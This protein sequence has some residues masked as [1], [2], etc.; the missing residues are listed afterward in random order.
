MTYTCS[1][2]AR[3]HAHASVQVRVKYFVTLDASTDEITRARAKDPWV[4]VRETPEQYIAETAPKLPAR[5]LEA[6]WTREI[7]DGS[8]P[9]ED[10]LVRERDWVLVRD[11][12]KCHDPHKPEDAYYIALFEDASLSSLRARST[13]RCCAACSAKHRRPCLSASPLRTRRRRSRSSCAMCSTSRRTGTCT[14][15]WS[16]CSTKCSPSGRAVT[17]RSWRSTAGTRSRM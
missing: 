5:K 7:I 8:K 6:S 17:S 3:L 4:R 11:Y 14:C 15:M 1:L 10:V 2:C 12:K 9:D 16:R 13:S